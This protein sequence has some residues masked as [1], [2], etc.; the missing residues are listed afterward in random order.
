[1][2]SCCSTNKFYTPHILRSH[3]F[4]FIYLPLCVVF[5]F[6]IL[7]FAVY[8]LIHVYVYNQSIDA[9]ENWFWFYWPLAL[10][11][12]VI[13]LVLLV[14]VWRCKRSDGNSEETVCILK[15][16]SEET[17]V[18]NASEEDLSEKK[19]LQS[20]ELEEITPGKAEHLFPRCSVR[21]KPEKLQIEKVVIHEQRKTACLSPRELFFKD[22]LDEANK[23][24]S[25]LIFNQPKTHEYFIASVSPKQK[26]Y[27]NN[28]FMYVNAG[29][30]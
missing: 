10:L 9:S 18:L 6:I 8:P 22:L 30:E 3:P 11:L 24:T 29:Q 17:V 20:I 4:R 12:F 23:S 16:N 7:W 28:I 15:K 14:C 5:L 26:N 1:M 2:P 27:K 19:S 21:R 25:S 13:V